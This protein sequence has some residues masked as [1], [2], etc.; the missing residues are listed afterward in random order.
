MNWVAPTPFA[1]PAASVIAVLFVAASFVM[2]RAA[3]YELRRHGTSFL[4]TQATT[5]LVRSGPYRFTRNP[6][7][8]AFALAYL[9]IAIAFSLLWAIVLL[10]AVLAAIQWS[11]IVREEDYLERKFREQYRVYKAGVRRWL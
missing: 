9:G 7:Y 3:L 6:M 11:V 5:A 8:L 1:R 10:P 4:P 2:I